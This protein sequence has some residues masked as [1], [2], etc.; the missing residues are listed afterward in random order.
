VIF[1]KESNLAD[2]KISNQFRIALVTAPNLK[3]A[4][5]LAGAALRQRL[6][7]CANLVPG[8]ESHYWWQGKMESSREVLI[9]FKTQRSRLRDLEKLI[10]NEHPYDTPEFVVANLT[11]GTERYLAWLAGE[12]QLGQ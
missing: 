5:R 10:L 12:T 6:V 7:A 1:G 4:R 9:L 2:L 3:T 8:V 11:A